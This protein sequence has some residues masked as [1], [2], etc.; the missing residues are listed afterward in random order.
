MALLAFT[1]RAHNLSWDLIRPALHDDPHGSTS[2]QKKPRRHANL[3][4][5]YNEYASLG[6]SLARYDPFEPAFIDSALKRQS[7]LGHLIFGE[8]RWDQIRGEYLRAA[9]NDPLTTYYRRTFAGASTSKLRDDLYN[10]L[11]SCAV[12][13]PV[14]RKIHCYCIRKLTR[15]GETNYQAESKQ[16]WSP[17]QPLPAD[18][19]RCIL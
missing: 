11:V 2:G 4:D 12:E 14:Q 13:P 18:V 15:F 7:N 5:G 8:R 10:L 6:A 3:I 16:L 1:D 9:V 19:D 17:L